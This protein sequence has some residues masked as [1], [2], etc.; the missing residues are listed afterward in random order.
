LKQLT[1][2]QL[3]KLL[4]RVLKPG[5]YI[6]KEIG[7]KSKDLSDISDIDSIVF[8][9]LAFPDVY[10]VGMSNLGIQ[11]LYDIINKHKDF[12]AERVFSPWVDFEGNLIKS[13]LK[14]FSIEN[15]IF[16]DEFDIV[17][18]SL[19][20]EL[21]FTNALNMLKLGRIAIKSSERKETDPLVCAGGPACFNPLPMAPF[22]D[23]FVIGDG[24][25]SF[26]RVLDVLKKKKK[27]RKSKK[28]FFDNIRDL[29]GIFIPEDYSFFYDNSG[30]LKKIEPQGKIRKAVLR[31]I[32]DFDIVKD[33]VIA[34]I[35]PVH[36]RFVCEIMRGCYRGCRFCQAG[37]IYR[38]VRYRD[39]DKLAEQCIEGIEKSG[40]DE[41]SFLSL[42]SADYPGLE[43]LINDFTGEIKDKKISVSLPSMR[44]DSF[45]FAIARI[46]QSGRKTGLTFAPEAGSQLMRD[47]INKNIDKNEMLK[48][49]ATAFGE[50]WE[51]VKLYFMIG[52]P[53]ERDED[54]LAI[55]ELVREILKMGKELL[56][57]RKAGRI[58]I[59]L[60]INAFCPKPFTP[61]QWAAQDSIEVLNEK[62]TKIVNLLPKK[63]VNV[64]WSD[65]RKSKL[66]CAVSKGDI[67]TAKAIEYAFK[68]GARFD[69]W[70]EFFN[71]EI[72]EEAFKEAGLDMD[73]Y[74]SRELSHEE[75]LCWD[76]ID[77][78]IKKDFLIK[79]NIK[80]KELLKSRKRSGSGDL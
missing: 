75:L 48:C 12:S 6:G 62:F 45:S 55:P 5:R 16:L 56:P 79:E 3:E 1:Y 70:S 52:F 57:G 8:A 35:K 25:E 40:Y 78:G 67:R 76:L 61:F 37:Y 22:M 46:I 47:A 36:D 30:I 49:M 80:A 64:S 33:P 69:N 24:E 71:F 19:Q 68:K 77:I 13:D 72:W 29:E 38:P 43:K 14:L 54:I 4:D 74:T 41:I 51:K 66:E 50:G 26:I 28:W 63:A 9:A 34:N 11:I 65:P 31:K 59:N 17:G 73:F 32:D 39:N 44:I 7:I 53:G 2:Q 20:H 23:F 15:R 27:E 18:I 21:Q 60:S 10:E 42:S 58:K